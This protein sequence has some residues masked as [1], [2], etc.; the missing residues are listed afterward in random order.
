MLRTHKIG[1]V[2]EK[3][4]GKKVKLC[5]WID[6]IRYFKS[7]VFLV[8]RDRYGKV[9]CIIP[10]DSKAFTDAGKLTLESSVKI[11]GEVKKRPKGQENKDM[12]K[13]GGVEISV[14]ELEAFNICP[15]LPFDLK[16]ENTEDIRLENRF[17]DLR[18][19]RMQK[20]IV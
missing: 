3:L 19:E 9:Q 2:D 16:A 7:M 10:K 6:S 13:Q 11:V 5:G 14:S 1:E 17:L 4:A 15:K 8:L 12:G 20:N 18:T